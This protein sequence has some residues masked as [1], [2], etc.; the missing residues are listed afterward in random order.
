MPVDFREYTA[1]ET[2]INLALL[3][4]HLRQFKEGDAKFCLECCA[5]HLMLIEGLSQEGTGFF[6]ED[7][8]FWE[9]LKQWARAIRK[10]GSR[11]EATA[12]LTLTWAEEARLYRKDIQSKYMGSMGECDC[13]SGFEP[14][15]KVKG[16]VA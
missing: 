13:V 14:C 1:D 12:T 7:P 2:A 11:G 8:E 15:C 16:K 10:K 3:E 9:A 5:K 6:P 4:T